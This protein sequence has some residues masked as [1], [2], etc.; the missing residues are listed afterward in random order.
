MKIRLYHIAW[1][2]CIF[3]AAI[4][5][6]M[7]VPRQQDQNDKNSPLTQ[8]R[9]IA[10]ADSFGGEFTLTDHHGHEVTNKSW[11]D[12]YR[13]IYFGFTFCPD[14]CP[15]GMTVIANALEALPQEFQDK[16]QPVFITV[17]PA[18]D[19]AETLK[20]YVTLFNPNFIGLTGSEEQIDHIKKLYK[21]YAEKDGNGDDYMINHSAFTYF[22]DPDGVLV[23]LYPHETTAKE[24]ADNI[25]QI[26]DH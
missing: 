21:I 2:L 16:I 22:T 9:P 17:D 5:F 20:Q 10:G 23:G 24:M 19:T 3:M 7:G 11:P 13:L 25:R 18:R 14:V 12:K 4:F 1:V 6:I 26:M 8:T 15:L